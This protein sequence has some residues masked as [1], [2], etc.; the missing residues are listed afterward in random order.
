MSR[1]SLPQN[2]TRTGEKLTPEVKILEER[3]RNAKDA[4]KAMAGDRLANVDCVECGESEKLCECDDGFKRPPGAPKPNIVA[5]VKPNVTNSR[6][7]AELPT[8]SGGHA[9]RK[10]VASA[11]GRSD[12]Y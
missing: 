12:W 9:I 5:P 8:K 1:I 11:N 2:F 4:A 6:I 10:P 7:V 3:L